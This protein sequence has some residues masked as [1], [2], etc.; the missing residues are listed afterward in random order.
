MNETYEQE[1]TPDPSV[2]NTPTLMQ[3]QP[4]APKKKSC[5]K[6]RVIINAPGASQ[7]MRWKDLS[8]K[9]RILEIIRYAFY[10]G[11][12]AV[13]VNFSQKYE[14]ALLRS[15]NPMRMVSK[16]INDF[17]N[18]AGLKEFQILM[19]LEV[20]SDTNRLHMHGVFIAGEHDSAGIAESLR[21]AAGRIPGKAGS[22][23]YKEDKLFHA[24][25][26]FKYISR[27]MRKT[28]KFLQ[29][30]EKRKLVWVSHALTKP[31]MNHYESIRLGKNVTANTNQIM[32]R[33]AS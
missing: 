4:R 6:S 12:T 28:R 33:P 25:G 8:F 1:V 9:Q 21:N 31:A 3:K 17:L 2:T 13:S 5:V 32:V 30:K 15:E 26:W 23:Q 7:I 27:D 29:L 24:E 10:A 11:G 14:E 19:V 22:R 16:R 18:R 20:A